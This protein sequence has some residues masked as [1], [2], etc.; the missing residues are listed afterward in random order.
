[1]PYL[2]GAGKIYNDL[3]MLPNDLF[4]WLVYPKQILLNQFCGLCLWNNLCICMLDARVWVCL[5]VF[6]GG[7]RLM[8]A[9]LPRGKFK[10]PFINVP[11]RLKT[12]RRDG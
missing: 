12:L 9:P 4:K 2:S 5:C 3:G 8:K 6:V 10:A 11:L 1:M 7:E